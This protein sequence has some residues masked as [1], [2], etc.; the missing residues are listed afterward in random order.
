MFLLPGAMYNSRQFPIIRVKLIS[1]QK[2]SV[3]D[4]P[5]VTYIGP[6]GDPLTISLNLFYKHYERAV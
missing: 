6:M 2:S 4:A 5:A 3:E 1:I